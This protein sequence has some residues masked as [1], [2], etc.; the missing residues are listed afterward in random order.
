MSGAGPERW[1]RC[2]AVV[3]VLRDGRDEWCWF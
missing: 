1:Y 2:V 3:L